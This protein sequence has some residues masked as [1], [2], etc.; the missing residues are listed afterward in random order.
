MTEPPPPPAQPPPPPSQPP[1]P[2]G[3]PP[4]WETP[5]AGPPGYTS[6]PQTDGLAIGALVTAIAGIFVCSVVPIAS[7]VALFLATNSNKKIRASGGQLSG[8]GM[9]KAAL[10]ISWIWIGLSV[11]FW[12]VIIIIGVTVGFDSD[13]NDFDDNDFGLGLQYLAVRLGF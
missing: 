12:V 3:P 8:E 10:I 13:D 9:N 7:V 6:A 1:P 5:A 2:A 4:G 11:L